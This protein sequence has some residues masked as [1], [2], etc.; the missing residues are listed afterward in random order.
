MWFGA[1]M[2]FALGTPQASALG[3]Y[4]GYL[5][6]GLAAL[7]GLAIGQ[8]KRGSRIPFAPALAAGTMVALWY[9][10]RIAAFIAG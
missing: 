10:D 1:M 4:V 2:G 8:V 6:G 9:G 5:F 3:L 7:I